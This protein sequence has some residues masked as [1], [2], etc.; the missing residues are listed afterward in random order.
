MNR[1]LTKKTSNIPEVHR[2]LTTRKLRQFGL[3]NLVELAERVY[4]RY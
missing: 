2:A 3:V 4:L 1:I